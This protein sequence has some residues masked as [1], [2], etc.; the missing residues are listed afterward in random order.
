MKFFFVL[1]V[2]ILL[3]FGSS[4]QSAFDS[5]RIIDYH[6]HIFSEELIRNLNT[7]GYDMAAS[8]FQITPSLL[9]TYSNLDSIN[10]NNKAF[11]MLLISAGYAFRDLDHG[12]EEAERKAVQR[13]N[14]LL[15]KLVQSNPDKFTGFAGVN[16]LK[17]FTIREI[18]RCDEVLKLDGI[19][20]HL[21]GCNVDLKNPSHLERVRKVIQLAAER[22]LPLLIHNNAWNI[23]EGALYA[24]IFIDSILNKT[25]PVTILFAH[26]G[27]G[28]L[29]F[30]FN[31]DFLTAFSNYFKNDPDSNRHKIFFELSGTVSVIDYPEE[32]PMSDLEQLML[33]IGT[34]R[35]LFGSDYPYRTGPSYIE[36]LYHELKMDKS[37]LKNIIESD[38]FR[39]L[40]Q[41]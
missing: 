30:N 12:G 8:G 1:S 37:I 41:H 7:Q 17:E 26:G 34:D 14:D 20:L 15:S 28:G 4:G 38:I 27:G 5:L 22:H 36:E 3:H 35:F 23:N 39:E 21:Q 11:K 13:E 25:D 24:G 31:H 40:K 33:D 10:R 6:V 2:L 29:Y 18:I 16:P 32:K 19:K 9:S